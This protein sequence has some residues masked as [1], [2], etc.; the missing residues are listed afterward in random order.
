M[1]NRRLKGYKALRFAVDINEYWPSLEETTGY[2][3]VN[4]DTIRNWIETGVIPAYKIG[5]Q[6]KFKISEIDKWIRIGENAK[7]VG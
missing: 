1:F 7:I 3:D 6:W 2:I 5:K 4:K